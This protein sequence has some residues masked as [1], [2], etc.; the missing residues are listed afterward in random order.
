MTTKVSSMKLAEWASC[1]LS[2]QTSAILVANL[3]WHDTVV[4]SMHDI[5]YITLLIAKLTQPYSTSLHIYA[6]MKNCSVGG[7]HNRGGIFNRK[8]DC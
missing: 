6:L 5:F 2:Q 4:T 1:I 8:L 3:F 7:W